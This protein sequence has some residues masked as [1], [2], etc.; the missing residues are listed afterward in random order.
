MSKN[1]VDPMLRYKNI[2]AEKNWEKNGV[3]SQNRAK[4]W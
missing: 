1:F 3:F 4:L 2:F